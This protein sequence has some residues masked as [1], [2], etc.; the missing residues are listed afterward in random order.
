VATILLAAA[1]AASQGGLPLGA[2]AA[3]RVAAAELAALPGLA[4]TPA[5][6]PAEQRACGEMLAAAG[7]IAAASRAEQ[8]RGVAALGECRFG[9]AAREFRKAAGQARAAVRI[10]EAVRVQLG[11]KVER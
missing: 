7:R 1:V 11:P 4:V 10:A 8:A 5:L 9:D 2:A 6:P 3:V